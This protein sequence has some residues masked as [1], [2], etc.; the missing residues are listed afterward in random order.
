MGISF[1][2]DNR[3]RVLYVEDDRD[4]REAV[5]MF[6]DDMGFQVTETDNLQDAE[7]IGRE[8]FDVYIVDGTFPRVP[9]GQA[10]R[11]IGIELYDRIHR[12]YGKINYAILSLD[13]DLEDACKA[14][15]IVFIGKSRPGNGLLEYL[16]G[17]Q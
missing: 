5:G 15:G 2:P 8:L 4:S 7:R 6:L 12:I 16:K 13:D 9:A 1:K 17:L 10:V 11:G 14:R 3:K